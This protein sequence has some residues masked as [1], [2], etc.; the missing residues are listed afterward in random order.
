MEITWFN[1]KLAEGQAS[2][3]ENSITLNK[4]AMSPFEG[5]YRVKVGIDEKNNIIIEPLSKDFISH[6]D[7]NEND[8]LGIQITK[9]YA[10]INSKE[11][12]N[13]V[14]SCLKLNLGK[15]VIKFPTK[16][17]EDEDHLI[18]LTGKGE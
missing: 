16:Y 11:L 14:S 3:N 13:L 12:M 10:R 17:I 7:L 18:I 4:T 9:S 2:L 15:E 5:A 1:L 8:F 6:M